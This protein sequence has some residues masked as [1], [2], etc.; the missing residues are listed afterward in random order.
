MVLAALFVLAV[1]LSLMWLFGR[2]G[3]SF[4][5]RGWQVFFIIVFAL[6]VAGL[7]IPGYIMDIRKIDMDN[8]SPAQPQN[9][10]PYA[11]RDF[12]K[13]TNECNSLTNMQ[14]YTISFMHKLNLKMQSIESCYSIVS[15]GAE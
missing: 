5:S 6:L 10:K 7:Q 3:G 15:G 11:T 2:L 1:G 4:I 8:P 14:D 13:I 12:V 9:P